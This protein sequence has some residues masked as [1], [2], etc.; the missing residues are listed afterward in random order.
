MIIMQAL[1]YTYTGDVR[2]LLTKQQEILDRV[3]ASERHISEMEKV[4]GKSFSELKTLIEEQD[5]RS[6]TVKN[7]QYEVHVHNIIISKL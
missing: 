6:F 3:K 7:S 2:L 5:K 1:Y 4:I